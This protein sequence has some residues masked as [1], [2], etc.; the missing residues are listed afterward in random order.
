M[1][2]FYTQMRIT[3]GTLNNI[4]WYAS[5]EIEWN[6]HQNEMAE[7]LCTAIVSICSYG[8]LILLGDIPR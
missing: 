7:S 4:Q 2:R 3:I 8:D 5:F 6:Y 1:E